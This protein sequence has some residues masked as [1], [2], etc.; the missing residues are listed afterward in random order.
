MKRLNGWQRLGIIASVI[1][2][3]AGAVMTLMANDEDYRKRTGWG[4]DRCWH[5]ADDA[6][7]KRFRDLDARHLTVEDERQ[8]A[9]KVIQDQMDAEY[10][11]CAD[12]VWVDV[13]PPGF[14][15]VIAVPLITL[16]IAWLLAYFLVG[17]GRWVAAGFKKA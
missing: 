5:Q 15:N 9:I 17:L 6:R 12:V 13:P 10:K 3:F 16:G 14:A 2:F 8:A 4:L 7:E 11:L 1:W